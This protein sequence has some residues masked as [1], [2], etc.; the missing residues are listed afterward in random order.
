MR[1]PDMERLRVSLT[2]NQVSLLNELRQRMGLPLSEII[3]R[4]VDEY[5]DRLAQDGRF[6]QEG[7]DGSRPKQR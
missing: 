3:R 2:Q 1:N 6:R 5:L 4:A 7:T